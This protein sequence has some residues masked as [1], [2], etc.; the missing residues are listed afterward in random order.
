MFIKWSVYLVEKLSIYLVCSL[1]KFMK[2]MILWLI[3]DSGDEMFN[4]I[5]NV[6]ATN[7]MCQCQ[8]ENPKF[9]RILYFRE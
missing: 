3:D 2:M 8:Y 7:E 9:S 6:R 1:S 4:E 5:M